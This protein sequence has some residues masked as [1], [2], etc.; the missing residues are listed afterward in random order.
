MA[1]IDDLFKRPTIPS[2]KRK[3]SATKDP[4]EI[5]KSIKLNDKANARTNGQTTVEDDPEEDDDV[6][7]PDLPPDMEDEAENEEDGRFFGGGI[8]SETADVLDFIDERDQDAVAKP[9]TIDSGW[10]RKLALNFERKISK[11][12]ELRAKFESTPQKFMGSEADL[13]ADVKALSI[14]SEHPE[15]YQEF[16]QLG[17]VSSLV[18]LL[19]HENTDIAIDAIEII[20]ELI[21]EDVEAE[22]AQWDVLVDALLDADLLDLLYQNLSRFDESVESDRIGAYHV[23]GKHFDSIRANHIATELIGKNKGMIPWLISRAQIRESTVSQ[24]KQYS[25]EILAIL[26]QTSA[27]NRKRFIGLDGIDA[28]LQ[29]LSAYRKRDPAKGTEEEEYVENV[30]DCVTCSVDEAEGKQKYLDGEGMELCL[31]MLKEG[32]MSRPRALRLMDHALGGPTGISCCEKLVEAAGLKVIFTMFM[33]KVDTQ[34]TEHLLGIIASMLR[35]LPGDSAPRIRLLGK[36]VEKNYEKID[37]LMQLRR[38]YSS[39]LSNVDQTIKSERATFS[40]EEHV[41]MADEWLS[42]RL[43]AG[44]FSLQ[45]IDT[46]L[47]WLVAEDDGAR[48]HIQQ[49]LADR[50]ETSAIIKGTLQ[51]QLAGINASAKEADPT[52]NDMLETLIAFL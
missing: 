52:I 15:L 37:R 25:A 6:A 30:F 7:G 8:T 17:C 10:V 26:L 44:L 32:K 50:D 31:I 33:K 16:A 24:N 11:N 29:L 3:L 40:A 13:D 43:D 39:R 38:E 19:S 12:A 2:Q 51:E 47:A 5:Y 21:D 42:R 48:A 23:L 20:G 18:S 34:S 36:F 1:S 35:S 27:T 45:S 9:E 49:L 46:T 14:L 28:F 4:N 41:D 22:Q